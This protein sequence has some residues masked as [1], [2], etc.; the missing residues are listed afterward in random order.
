[1]LEGGR[2][3]RLVPC[4]DAEALARAIDAALAE[5]AQP[6]K[7]RD[8]AIAMAGPA[9]IDRYSELLTA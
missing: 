2:Y 4:G 6:K 7:M 5:P 3:G 1:M 8:R 9:K